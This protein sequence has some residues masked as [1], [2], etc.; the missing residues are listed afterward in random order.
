MSLWDSGVLFILFNRVR[1]R[2]EH[3]L[4]FAAVFQ[5]VLDFY[6]DTVYFRVDVDDPAHAAVVFILLSDVHTHF[7]DL[8][9][10]THDG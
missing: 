1:A 5:P 2:C 4:V 9:R 6:R 3:Q 7:Y 10:D 8:F